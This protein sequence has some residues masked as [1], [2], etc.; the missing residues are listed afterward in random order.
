MA[1]SK[2]VRLLKI[3]QHETGKDIL[4]NLDK[5]R[6]SLLEGYYN[7]L[8]EDEQEN[9]DEKIISGEDN[10]FA[11]VAE[12]MAFGMIN[13]EV[14]FSKKSATATAERPS[15][16]ALAIVPKPEKKGTDIVDEDIDP[17]ILRV[18][19]LDDTSDIDYDTYKTLLRAKIAEGRMPGSKMP[20]EEIELLTNEFKKVKGK[21]GRFKVK[22][23]SIRAES[24]VAK[25]KE[26]T[27]SKVAKPVLALKGEKPLQIKPTEE[28]NDALDQAIKL[29]AGKISEVDEK[30]K[31][32]IDTNNKKNKLEKKQD[33]KTRIR[34]DKS[35]K[36]IREERSERSKDASS[37]VNAFGK[38]MAP[39]KGVLDMVGDFVK[40][41][42]VGTLVMEL[43]KFL[44]N[45]DQYITGLINGVSNWVNGLIQKIEDGIKDIISTKIVPA[46]NT[47]IDGFNSKL[48]PI[49]NSIN[50]LIDRIPGNFVPKIDPNQVLMGRID[51]Q[52]LT[53]FSLPQIPQF[54]GTNF[55]SNLGMTGAGTPPP[56]P[57]QPATSAPGGALP[58]PAGQTLASGAKTTYYDPS[59]GGINASGY[60]TP[61]GL[62]A[63][64]TGEGYRANVFSAAAFP[65]LLSKLP[66]NMTV[67]ARGFPGGRTLKKAFNVVVTNSQGKKAVIRVNDVGPGVAG[68]ASNHMLD[69]SVAAKNYLGTGGGFT[70]E[71]APPGAKPGPVTQTSSASRA[72][73]PPPAASPA[74]SQGQGSMVTFGG[75][76]FYQNPDGTLTHPSAAPAQ[77][78]GQ[79]PTQSQA[80]VAP[81]RPSVPVPPPPGSGGL[82]TIP[83]PVPTGGGQSGQNSSS[84]ASQKSVPTF[85]AYD[86]TNPG[87]FVIKSI[88]NIVG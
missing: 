70:I 38:A 52:S 40:K 25:K 71:M 27:T 2:V 88:Y 13:G 75:Q 28:T 77:I 74:S 23:R 10:D 17:L 30:V 51:P 9:I 32:V 59:L 15:S 43:L 78:A 6:L 53:S 33:E 45:P 11:E 67:P 7:S 72:S 16:S 39:V 34:D 55:F 64:S 48:L 81:S 86:K 76:T 46:I 87:H 68:H 44:E 85:S 82:S 79:Q 73:S 36:I 69:F 83:I 19:E 4:S 63:T 56:Q 35:R 14:A 8:T 26:A 80:T 60:K 47:V 84:A 37:L 12:G 49:I 58:G 22:A 24:F 42:L 50:S 41:F 29:L 62:P 31:E 3:I 18:L 57:G 65:P 54:Q 21:T 66:S 61:D 1:D 5:K 20:T